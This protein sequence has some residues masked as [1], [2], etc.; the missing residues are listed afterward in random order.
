MKIGIFGGT[1]DPIHFGHLR[2]GVEAAEALNLTRV[3]FVPSHT[4]PHKRT[5][6][7][8]SGEQRLEMV[9]LAV[10]P[11]RLLEASDVEIARGGKSFTAETLEYF[12]K[13]LP[14]S[15]RVFLVGLDAFLEIHTWKSF[16]SLF[17]LADFAVLSRPKTD[18]R[19]R[20]EAYIQESLGSLLTKDGSGQWVSASGQKLCFL[21]VTG[22]D[23]SATFI[24]QSVGQSRDISFLMPE[25]VAGYIEKNR[26]YKKEM[27]T[28]GL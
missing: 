28:K 4:A 6:G 17:S 8:A 24:R 11:C 7:L 21:K 27:E 20:M 19:D 1:F 26:L 3:Y 2:A 25:T 12:K 13:K 10:A 22:M 23:I 18:G 15:K 16:E 5:G 9:R 14:G